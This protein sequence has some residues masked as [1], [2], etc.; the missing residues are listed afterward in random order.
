MSTAPEQPTA[1]PLAPVRTTT[2]EI[3]GRTRSDDYEWLREKESPEV[4]AHL[5]ADLQHG[6]Y[7]DDLFR[8]YRKHLGPVRYRILLEAQA[9]IAPERVRELLGFRKIS[10]LSLLIRPYKLSRRLKL[11][12]VLK[13]V[14]LPARY[15]KQIQ[16]LDVVAVAQ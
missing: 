10:M 15:K 1:P 4:L 14:L 6:P 3:H 12:R 11:D 8:Q 16:A 13:E 7:T 9:L 2:R 5:E